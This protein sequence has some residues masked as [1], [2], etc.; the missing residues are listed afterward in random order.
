[1]NKRENRFPFAAMLGQRELKIAYLVNIVNPEIGGL[2]ISGPKG[3][4]KS[5]IVYAAQS[6]LPEVDVAEGCLFNCLAEKD[7]PKCSECVEKL[8][9]VDSLPRIKKKMRV[10]ALPLST[11]E[12]RLIGSIDI[13]KLLRSGEK[14][15]QPGILGE[16]NN[17]IL[18][19][20][21]VN[22]LPDHIVDDILDV[23]AS[24]WNTI[25]REGVSCVHPSRFILVGTMN[26]EEGELRPQILDRFPLSV[27]LKSVNDIEERKEIIKRNILF[28]SSPEKLLQQ[29]EAETEFYAASILA[30]REILP[31]VVFS[32][33]FL[34]V[35]AGA[36]SKLKVDGQRPDIVIL[37]TA[38]T[39]AALENRKE[40]IAQDVLLAAELTLGHRTRDGGLLPPATTEEIHQAFNEMLDGFKKEDL[41]AFE[42]TTMLGISAKKE[43]DP[44]AQKKKM[45]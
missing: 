15:I 31:A 6:I 26:P 18:Y 10:V 14:I 37:K 19:I 38:I 25:E 2:L 8:K 40:I 36:C 45:N 20:D 27:K 7:A 32:D 1:M 22:L 43:Q 23:S 9:K 29:F 28:E 16:A 33:S 24:H 44:L 30:A 42:K 34:T 5:T 11:T 39:I 41:S 13:E 4:G 35:I 12:D 17:N 3:T 21:E